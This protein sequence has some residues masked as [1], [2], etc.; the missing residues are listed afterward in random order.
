MV[1]IKSMNGVVL[2]TLINDVYSRAVCQWLLIYDNVETIESD[3][4]CAPILANCE[5]RTGLDYYQK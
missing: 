3:R 2:K 5:Q 1:E 4:L